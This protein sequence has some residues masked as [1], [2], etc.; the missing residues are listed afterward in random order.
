MTKNTVIAFSALCLAL[1]QPAHGAIQYYDSDGSGANNIC[2]TG[3]GLGGS[4]SWS[5]ATALWTASDCG[6]DADVVWTEGN[7]AFFWGTAGLVSLSGPRTAGNLTFQTAGYT[8]TNTTLT[9][10]GAG[11]GVI[12]LPGSGTTLI[13][14]GL[15]GTVGYSVV[16]PGTLKLTNNVLG[17]ITGPTSVTSGAVLELS[18]SGAIGGTSAGAGN[19]TLNNGTYQDD[20]TT[21][22]SLTANRLFN[23]GASGGALN[24][25]SSAAILI[26]NGLIQGAGNTLTVSGAGDI[27]LQTNSVNATYGHNTF[28][29]LVV[30]TALVT[31]GQSTV[32]GVDECLG[33]TPGSFLADAV[34]LKNGGKIRGNSYSFSLSANRGITINNG[35]SIGAVSGFTLTV[36]GQ[37]TSPGLLTINANATSQDSGAVFFTAD[38]S[39]T[40]TGKLF[41][42]GGGLNFNTDSNLGAVP[43]SATPDAITLTNGAFLAFNQTGATLAANRGITL[44]NG[45][46]SIIACIASV[47]GTIAGVISGTGNLTKSSAT[48]SLVLTGANTYSGKTTISGGTLNVTSLNKVTSG[49]AS[50]SLGH[51]TTSANGTVSIG[52]TTVAGTLL[53]TGT[54]ET[55]DRIVDLAGTT[56][57]AVIDQSGTG[58]LKFTA[59]NTASGN[60]P[61]VLTLQGSTAGTGE[62][63]GSIPDGPTGSTV[64]TASASSGAASLTLASVN[65]ISVGAAVTGTSIPAGTTVL[66]ITNSTLKITISAAITATISSGATITIP[67]VKNITSLAHSGTGTWTISGVN[68]YSGNTTNL[69]SGGNGTLA[70][71]NAAA[72]GFGT[73]VQAA[74]SAI[75]NASGSA[76]TMTNAFLFNNGSPTFIGTS[77]MT[78]SGPVTISAANR[79][80]TV[81][82]GTLT[83]SG[84]GGVGQDSGSRTLTKAGNGTLVLAS[85]TASTYLGATTVSGGTLRVDGTMASSAVT[86]SAAGT[87]AGN[88]TVPAVTVNGTISPGAGPGTLTT[89]AA[90]L[91][92]GGSYVWEINN[93][94][95]SIGSAYDTINATSANITATTG[96]KFNI[97]VTSLNGT[98]AG[99][100]ANF[101]GNTDYDFVILHASGAITGNGA[102]AINVD[103]SAFQNTV[104]TGGFW[105]VT[106][107]GSDLVLS[108]RRAAFITSNPTS[109]NLNAG[110]T[111]NFAGSAT[112]SGTVSYQWKKGATALS[113]GA[114]A[115]GSVVSGATTANLTVS[116]VTYQDEGAYTLVATGTY[117]AAATSTAASLTVTDPP[118]ITSPVAASTITTNA[119]STIHLSVISTGRTGTYQWKK[120]GVNLANGAFDNAATVA[121]SQ[122][123]NLTLAAVMAADA[124]V[125]TVDLTTTDGSANTDAAGT[126]LQV[127]DPVFT[128]DLTNQAFN[129]GTSNALSVV[130]AGTTNIAYQWYQGDTN[131]STVIT[132]ATNAALP[133]PD[134]RAL[135][136]GSYF[137]IATNAF[138]NS[139]TSFVATVTVVDTLAP[140]ITQNAGVSTVECHTSYTDAGAAATDACEGSISVTTTGAVDANTP[141]TYTITYTA[142]DSVPNT[143]TSF[144]LVTVSD[145]IAPVV[146]INP[147]ATTVECHSSFS[148]PGATASDACD[149]GV[150]ASLSGSVNV[151]LPGTYTLTYSAT[152]ASGHT[153][154][155]IRVVTVSDNVA[156][157]VTIN[158]GATTVECH[159]SF[160]NPG[161]TVSDDC[162]TALTTATL[163]G[164]VDANTPGTYTLTY[165]ATDAT[166]NTS[167][168]T[169]VVTVSD[170]TAPVVT[171]NAG[172]TTVECHTSFTNP[173]ATASDAC[174]AG[175]TTATLSGSVN[176][177]TPGN[178]TLIYSAT[179]AS[180][181]TGTATRVVTVSDSIAPVVSISG[182]NPLTLNCHDSFSAPGATASDACDAAVTTATVTS[183]SVNPNVVGA[184]TLTYS[185]TDASGNTGSAT[186]VVNVVDTTPPS[187]A[188]TGASLVTV[189]CHTAYTELGATASDACAG[190]VTASIVITGSFDTNTVG[191]YTLTYTASDNVNTASALRTVQ[192]TDT[193]A[194]EITINAGATTVECHTSF[195]NP[196]ATASDTCDAGVTNAT[197]TGSVD[198]NTPGTYTLTY[199]ATDASGNSGSATRA[200]TV[201]DSTAPVVTIN[202]GPTTVECHTSFSNPGA[203][204]SDTCDAGVTTATLSGGSVNVNT[205]GTY[206]LTYSATDASSNTGTA[207]RV[208]TVSDTTAP[209]VTINAGPSTVECHGSFSNPGA[210]A[211]DSCDETLTTATLTGSVNANTPGVYTLT[212]SATDAS[213][214]TSSATRAVTVNDTT[215]PVITV[216]G[217][218]P[219]SVCQFTVYTDAGATADDACTG[220]VS[221]TTTGTVDTS[222]AGAYTLTYSAQDITGNSSTATRV[223]NVD[224]LT[225]SPLLKVVG[226]NAFI[227]VSWPASARCYSLEESTTLETNS[228]TSVAQTT[229]TNA[230]E[231][232]MTIPA[233]NGMRFFR[234]KSP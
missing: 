162:D 173:G 200:I 114:Q 113:N 104:G 31:I 138:G 18:L 90:T 204:A 12:T 65:G 48:G 25:P 57:G 41:V 118:V 177:N 94:T 7:D 75:D 181:N 88:G 220:I 161:A 22:D 126:T 47:T 53:Y 174:D 188:L 34:T 190:D 223:V 93:L 140:V 211:S 122:S 35:G 171:I 115:G 178:Y 10:A 72:L 58:L 50:S 45:S 103:S 5:T 232:S 176:V 167:T 11:K 199:T 158:P 29:K 59:A 116:G 33:A 51:P 149:P 70:F 127:V 107:S 135:N 125:Y 92:G 120:G 37:I 143:A 157:V 165:S 109:L 13:T 32:G 195:S 152:D 60:A 102:T 231:L 210:T 219:E 71:G 183:G 16:G 172:P 131:A 61:K 76:M 215:T 106:V 229:T 136:A 221:V 89:G 74:N 86:V 148:N 203:T 80:V 202:D 85:G 213:G 145:N 38:N 146:T 99:S 214:N 201:S 193:T 160:T 185:A 108:Y 8:I 121:G 4:G 155:A 78:I 207:T 40:I 150:T 73:Y 134:S 194:P 110:Q 132:D 191:T 39:S 226:S 166:G 180:G 227:V 6:T 112:S 184:Y 123:A 27:R 105:F 17:A 97:K 36:P 26:Y 128:T 197:L 44:G 147:G 68:T 69:S 55:T 225:P 98:A 159:S 95:G 205:P 144:R 21:V 19:I 169:R 151:N 141:G 163:S 28:S 100:A 198:A 156:P 153:G 46:S 30:D 49:S 228:W 212:Y 186:L 23:I 91:A 187:I 182:S 217:N 82:A 142:S 43:A 15:A 62:I 206:T 101:D 154:S 209:V 129:C 216:A 137:V 224:P 79:T 196:G 124:G 66:G 20:T 133:F 218:S 63:S 189:E 9:L 170:H 3:V 96:S 1:A 2:A 117:G 192:V 81:N 130:V 164:S 222:V 168:A 84:T 119:G 52:S 230:S 139:I 234:L 67:G 54:G 24:I 87:L 64:T 42:K 14:S 208:V 179:D 77:D 83:L 175:V 111:A 233:T 56:G